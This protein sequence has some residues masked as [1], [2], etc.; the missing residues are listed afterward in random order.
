MRK[1]QIK[2]CYTEE[3]T[4]NFLR[5]L[6]IGLSGEVNGKTVSPTLQGIQYCAKVQGDG[7]ESQYAEDDTG[8]TAK[9][10]VESEVI[11]IVQYFI[12]VND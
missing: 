10:K 9:A 7:Y 3:E 4:N 6:S 8:I 2:Y 1:L 5:T 12:E 11:A